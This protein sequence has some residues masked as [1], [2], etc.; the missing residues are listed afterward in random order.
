MTV[1]HVRCVFQNSALNSFHSFEY[2]TFVNKQAEMEKLYRDY[3][4]FY[5]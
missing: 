1:E 3:K 5:Y 4:Q 2:S